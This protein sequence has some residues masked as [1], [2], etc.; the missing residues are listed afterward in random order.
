VKQ[1]HQNI[2]EEK[3]G[4]LI[5]DLGRGMKVHMR[6]AIEDCTWCEYSPEYGR[7]LNKPAAGKDWSTH[8]NWR[9]SNRLC[10]NCLGKGSVQN[11]EVITVEEV[12]VSEVKGIQMV[13]GRPALIP[14]GRIKITGNLS[15][16]DANRII[17]FENDEYSTITH[18][19]QTGLNITTGD[20]LLEAWIKI[21]TLSGDRII[22]Q[23][24]DGTT[25]Y[26]FFVNGEN[27]NV[28]VGDGSDVVT[29]TTNLSAGT[30]T[31]NDW[32][33][34]GATIDKSDKVKIYVDD[35]EAT[36]YSAQGVITAVGDI[37]NSS[38][39]F[40]GGNNSTDS[41]VGSIDEIRVWDFGVSGLPSDITTI[42]YNHFRYAHAV[43]K[44]ADQSKIKGWWIMEELL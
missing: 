15:D 27:L 44:T 34:V 43:Y 6:A 14:V 39:F 37:S 4:E 7:S 1:K 18:A 20:I 30:I 11:N 42:V 16:I 3:I 29:T 33:Y 28:T 35:T 31:D 12:I 26:K 32:H 8:P 21:D 38:D 25:G 17:T 36:A 40:I 23:K 41:L 10:P 22:L 24:Y 5:S 13:N 2:V 19:S 9:N